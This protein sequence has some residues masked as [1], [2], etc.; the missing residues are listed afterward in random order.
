MR[1]DS[2]IKFSE[3]RITVVEGRESIKEYYNCMFRCSEMFVCLCFF[4]LLKERWETETVYSRTQK[5]RFCVIHCTAIHCSTIYLSISMKYVKKPYSSE[6]FSLIIIR[7]H[8]KCTSS[9]DWDGIK[10]RKK[11]IE[12]VVIQSY[13]ILCSILYI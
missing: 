3:R 11:S 2:I 13:N 12:N 6:H 7:K 4:L 8:T 10:N 9:K 5:C 1:F